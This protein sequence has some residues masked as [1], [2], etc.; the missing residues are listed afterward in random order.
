MLEVLE[1]WKDVNVNC[2][3]MCFYLPVFAHDIMYTISFAC[4]NEIVC[5]I[6]YAK[7]MK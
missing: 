2:R 7:H 5:F 1:A 3:E 6:E 4:K